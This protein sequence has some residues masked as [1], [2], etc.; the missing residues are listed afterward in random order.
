MSS[1]CSWLQQGS[2]ESPPASFDNEARAK[3]IKKHVQKTIKQKREE[4]ATRLGVSMQQ[5]E[6]ECANDRVW[7]E[8]ELKKK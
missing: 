8:P 2:D 4:C 6:V 3:Y 5:T 1:S 7:D